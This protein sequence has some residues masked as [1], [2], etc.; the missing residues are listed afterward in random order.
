MFFNILSMRFLG[1]LGPWQ[2]PLGPGI[3]A[4]MVISPVSLGLSA[5]LGDKFSLGRIR[6][7]RTV[8]QGHF[9][10]ADGNSQNPVSDFIEVPKSTGS[11]SALVFPCYYSWYSVCT[12]FC[13]DK[14]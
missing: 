13:V 1:P 6:V 3:G 2:V 11:K 12:F 8:V 10:G 7:Q 14:L 4:V 9:L 5:F